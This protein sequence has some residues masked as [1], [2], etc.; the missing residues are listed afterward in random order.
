MTTTGEHDRSATGRLPLLPVVGAELAVPLVTRGTVR[1]ANLDYAASAPALESVAERVRECLT[2][3]SSVHRGS[4]WPSMV[5]TALYEQARDTVG[6]FVGARST[7][8]VVFTRNTTDSFNLLASVVPADCHVVHL[9]TEHH[10]NLL[11]WQP[12]R[13]TTVPVAGTVG[14]T[15]AALESVLASVTAGASGRTPALLSITGA[16]NVTGE[17]P[18]LAEVVALARAYGA[19]VAVDGAQLVP[20][21][22]VD[23]AAQGI[24]YLAFSGHKLYA[25]FGAGALIGKPD[26]LDS[27]APYLRG[28]G[29]VHEVSAVEV[30]WAAAPARH[31]GGTPNLV[32]AVALAA[33]CEALAALPA[34]SL[35]DHE[36]ALLDR[37]DTGL[38]E[39]PEVGPLRMWPRDE[40]DR[41]AVRAF[42]VEG[43]DPQLLAT[44]LSAEHGIGVRSGRFCA[45]QLVA[46]LVPASSGCPAAPPP[47]ALRASMGVGST[48]ADVDRL[49]DA[50]RELLQKGEAWNYA[51]Q[52]G[53][54]VPSPDPRSWGTARS[55]HHIPSPCGT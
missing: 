24:D 49:L 50:L 37:L 38:A 7:D 10:G 55:P 23:M 5:S 12:C 33:A 8:A 39:L 17:V 25:P 19:R 52:D 32:G 26:W 44:Y 35:R 46:R 3:Y 48:V 42:T 29:A 40:V 51:R 43:R 1:Y 36:H 4:G 13:H 2:T 27:G 47:Q 20:H 53:Q 6:A 41:V 30:E 22:R 16:G 18:P 14:E 9:D 31:E 21:R 54:W 15:L 11:S 45:H 28:G 34:D